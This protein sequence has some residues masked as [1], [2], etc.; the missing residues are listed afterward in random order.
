MEFRGG[1][2]K[3]SWRKTKRLLKGHKFIYLRVR[4]GLLKLKSLNFLTY[5]LINSE[6]AHESILARYL[7][8]S[9][10][11]ARSYKILQDGRLSKIWQE[12]LVRS[13]KYPQDLKLARSSK[14][15]LQ[16][17]ARHCFG[18]IEQDALVSSCKI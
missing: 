3:F 16:V 2:R 11:V 14:W 9:Y 18:K 6:T 4:L 8:K 10:Q 15:I 13:Y 12:Y 7:G 1:I 17:L 5:E